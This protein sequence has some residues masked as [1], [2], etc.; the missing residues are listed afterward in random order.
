MKII[1]TKIVKASIKLEQI[2]MNIGSEGNISFRE[3]ERIFITPS[4]INNLKLEEKE[5]AEVDLDGKVKNKKIPSSEV[6]MHVY[7]YQKR[8]EIKSI[9]HCHSTWASILS[10][11][12]INISAFHYM[13]AEFGGIDIRCCKYA[14]FGTK[15]LALNVL[16]AIKDRNGCLISNHGQITISKNI[17]DA[18]NLAIALEKLSKQ[19]YFC[20]LSNKSK[21]LEKRE[22]LDVLKLFENYK[23]KH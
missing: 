20:L 1:K 8:P 22:M 11:L 3:G 21:I 2:G 9:V 16:A 19:Y 7:I 10:C 15:K 5:I 14:T 13:V 6:F 18:I 23:V 4:G 17:E 12:R